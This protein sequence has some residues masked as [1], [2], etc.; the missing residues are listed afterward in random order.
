MLVIDEISMVSSKSMDS[1]DQQCKIVKNLDANS[2]AVF[3]G[4]PL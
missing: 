2:T 4:L 1:I 3:G